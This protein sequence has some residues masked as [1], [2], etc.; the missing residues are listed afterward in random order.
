MLFLVMRKSNKV[1]VGVRHKVF[2][3][4]LLVGLLIFL[5]IRC[6]LSCIA[7]VNFE[8]PGELGEGS[9]AILLC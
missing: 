4:R 7:A 5:V 6:G 8:A 2:Q 9:R 3:H 1:R